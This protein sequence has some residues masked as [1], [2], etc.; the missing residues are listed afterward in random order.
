LSTDPYREF[1]QAIDRPE[2]QIDL[3]R[4]ALT[5]ALPD[6]PDLD[7]SLYLRRIDDLAVEVTQRCGADADGFRSLAALNQVLFTRHGFR[8][9]RDDY[10]DPKNSF[11]NQVLERKCGIP[12]TLSVLFMEVAQRVGLSV[13]GVGFPGHFL[14]KAQCD[15]DEVVIDPFRRGDVKSN[16]DLQQLLDQM[17]GGKVALRPEFLAPMGKKQILKRMLDNLKAIYGRGEDW[18]KLIAVLDRIIIIDP[19]AAEEVRDRGAVY[20]RLECHA[21]A[22][23]D[24]ETYLQLAPD[25]KDAEGIRNHLIDLAKPAIL[26]H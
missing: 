21:Q 26:L 6:F 16:E 18:L 24:F 7:I 13:A 22:K 14:V 15:D 20:L 4:A 3:G 8:G 11:L 19:A 2:E 5:I 17:F 9:N 25:A 12:I 1:C 23:A 10:Y